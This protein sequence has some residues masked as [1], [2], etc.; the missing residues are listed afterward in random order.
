[1]Q[2]PPDV[3]KNHN[4]I[5]DSLDQEIAER[6]SNGTAQEYVN[7]T[8]ML[9]TAPTAHDLAVFVSSGGILMTSLWTYALYGFG[10]QIP[11]DRIGV[12]TKQCPDVLLVE[13]EAISQASLAYAAKQVGARPYVWSTVGL[14]GDPNTS[15]ALLD[16]GMNPSS[17][18]FSP[19]YGNLNF[20]DKIVGWND[21]VNNKST[22]YDDEGHGSN[23]AGLAGGDGFFP[24]ASSGNAIAQES[25][26]FGAISSTNTYLISGI[27]VNKTGTIKLSVKWSNTGSGASQLSTLYLYYGDKTASSGSWT[28]VASVNTPSQNTWYSLSYNVASTPSGGY[29]MYH[30]LTALTRA[31]SSSSSLYV[32][33]N[34]SWPYT[35][36]SDGFQAWTGIAPQAKLVE[37]KVLN[38]AGS[39]TSTGL[40]NGI[41]WVIGHAKSYHITVAS[42]SLGF[43]SEVTAVDNAVANLV[44]AGITTVCAAGNS[45]AGANYIFT[46]GSVD[47][48]ITVAAMNEFDNVTSYSSQGGTSRYDGLNHKPDIT[49]PGR[50]LPTA[51]RLSAPRTTAAMPLLCRGR[52]WRRR[53]SLAPLT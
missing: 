31:T 49:A 12:F 20:S 53:S 14:Q 43:S 23:T 29:N 27:M 16:T 37:I 11:Y 36:P 5:A 40:I 42:M 44:N 24:T 33:F 9:T 1:M 47:T 13:K 46:P 18:D 7:V 3:D 41:N 15:I 34:M 17:A 8:V 21:Q 38:G 19:G 52:P 22:P 6:P 39:G 10:G 32:T 35:P 4:G 2:I 28:P 51:C 45:G 25:E 48:V 30:I 50:Q 26:N